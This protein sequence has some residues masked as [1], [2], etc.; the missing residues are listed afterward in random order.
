MQSLL[1]AYVQYN[2]AMETT[3]GRSGRFACTPERNLHTILCVFNSGHLYKSHS[4]CTAQMLRALE[5]RDNVANAP[6]MVVTFAMLAVV[7]TVLCLALDP[8]VTVMDGY[9]CYA[10]ISANRIWEQLGASEQCWIGWYSSTIPNENDGTMWNLF[11]KVYGRIR[12]E[13]INTV[14]QTLT[15]GLHITLSF[16]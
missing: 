16:K 11:I 5:I 6:R 12:P 10:I 9:Y 4:Y 13:C 1:F 14:Q 7:F 3:T 8:W 15:I 2:I